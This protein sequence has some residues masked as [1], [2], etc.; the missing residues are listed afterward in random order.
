MSPLMKLL[1]MFSTLFR[2]RKHRQDDITSLPFW[3]F[4]LSV[5]DI[6]GR[7]TSYSTGGGGGAIGGG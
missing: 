5:K 4:L 2:K 7:I 1:Q 6:H 3:I